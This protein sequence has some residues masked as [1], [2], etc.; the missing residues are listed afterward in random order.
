S[1]SASRNKFATPINQGIKLFLNPDISVK[2]GSEIEVTQYGITKVF[3]CS[4]QPIVYES[5]QEIELTLKDRYA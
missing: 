4:S 2:A 5:H 3:D 1:S